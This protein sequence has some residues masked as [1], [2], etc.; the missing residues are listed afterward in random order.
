ME[1]ADRKKILELAKRNFTIRK[2]YREHQ[3]L[4]EKLARLGNKRYL[5]AQE[6]VEQ[7]TLKIRKLRGVDTMLSLVANAF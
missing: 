1:S 3:D 7:K 4:E 2:L 6:E 5:T